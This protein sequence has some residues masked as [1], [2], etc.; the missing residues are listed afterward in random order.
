MRVFATSIEPFAKVRNLTK[1]AY[2]DAVKGHPNF[3]PVINGRS[4]WL[5][6]CPYCRN[7]T[8]IVDMD[9]P[10]APIARHYLK[11]G[12]PV[13]RLN[14][15]AAQNCRYYTGERHGN[16]EYQP[17]EQEEKEFLQSIRQALLCRYDFW[18]NVLQESLG[19]YLMADN[20]GRMILDSYMKEKSFRL[21]FINYCNFAP[22]LLLYGGRIALH[23]RLVILGSNLH[24][25]LESIPGV[26]FEKW[27]DSRRYLKIS[28]RPTIEKNKKLFL[29]PKSDSFYKFEKVGDGYVERVSVAIADGYSQRTEKDISC[30]DVIFDTKV[31]MN[32]QD[33]FHHK[34]SLIEIA[35]EFM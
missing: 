23:G 8:Q 21:K 13:G 5:A 15:R 28:Y 35:K 17:T 32:L 19:L 20:T 11:K 27:K 24:H 29:Y 10:K 22:M 25:K 18:L 12:L 3:H 31:L 16:S 1:D 7:P 33:H 2:L 26:Q 9:N 30:F 34:P 14:F 4:V 6:I